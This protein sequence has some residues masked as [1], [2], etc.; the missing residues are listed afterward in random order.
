RRAVR[1]RRREVHVI[2][3]QPFGEW[4][5]QRTV[6]GSEEL[7]HARDEGIVFHPLRGVRR[8]R[9]ANGKVT[10]VELA[11]VVQVYDRQGRYA[12]RYGAHA[13]EVLECD[14][15]FLAVGQ[16][17]ELDYL[18]GTADVAR[19]PRGLIDVDPET[20]AT[21][22]PGVFAGGD[23]AFGPRT[24]IEAVAD[25]K[26]AARSIQAYFSGGRGL[27]Q[28]WHF[29]EV[30]P[31][32]VPTMDGYDATPREAPPCTAVGR[33]TGIAE[34]EGP[35]DEQQA[36]EQA[37]RCLVCHV[38]TI[39]DG[40]LCIACGRC[41]EIC[42]YSCLSFAGREDVSVDGGGDVLLDMQDGDV[43]MVKDEDRCVRCG[44]C[45]ERCPT[46]AMT[47]ERFS[48]HAEEARV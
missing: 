7:D 45:A 3:R 37:G 28:T 43:T 48:T 24:V 9:G 26:R 33:R 14:T 17:P 39:Y 15:L 6:R 35:Y 19:T 47:M 1:G 5:A 21:K 10:A 42:P 8:V 44:L 12:P 11:E 16:E 2:A 32:A 38:Q 13:A 22:M 30:H 18:Q 31:R 20:L 40:D 46:G 41:T 34:V 23:A 4:P 36:R 29:E 27:P 25:G